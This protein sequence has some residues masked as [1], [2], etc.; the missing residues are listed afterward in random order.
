[1]PLLLLLLFGE[2]SIEAVAK[3]AAANKTLLALELFSREKK[4]DLKK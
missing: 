1:M 4:L 3:V 2:T